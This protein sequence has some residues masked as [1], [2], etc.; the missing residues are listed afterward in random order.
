[1]SDHLAQ[2][3]YPTTP[4]VNKGPLPDIFVAPQS[5]S[6]I[7]AVEEWPTC[8]Q[9]WLD[10]I[11]NDEYGGMPPQPSKVQFELQST[12]V[13]RAWPGQPR[14]WSYKVICHGGEQSISFLVKVL[15]PQS[16]KP[17]PVIINGDACWW[18]SEEIAKMVV[19][20]GF[21]LLL[22]D[23]TELAQDVEE[24]RKIPE[25]CVGGLYDVY[26]GQSFGALSAWAWAYQRCVDLVYELPFLD[27]QSITVSGHSRGGKTCLIAAATDERITLINDNASCAA[28]GAVFRYV[29]DCGEKLSNIVRFTDWFP[30]S[31]SEFK[32]REEDLLYDQHC[33]LAAL[34]PR[35]LLLTYGIDD[36]WSNPEGMVQCV[37]AA[38]EAYRLL[39]MGDKIAFHLRPG[40][41]AHNMQ[42]WSVLIDFIRW[43]TEG[44]EPTSAFN[45]HPYQHLK[46]IYDWAVPALK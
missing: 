14:Y 20:E 41:H 5:Q 42:D 16:D 27:E 29:G 9:A 18:R 37:W 43:Q 25:Q 23:R 26:P 35:P 33:L 1:M 11:I 2:N 4:S 31:L 6:R 3:P 39:G 28:G 17:V 44:R 13:R 32:D 19:A 22:F 34:A 10:L 30:P 36:R 46:P 8:V 21:G 45:Q 7:E 40:T 12:H 38:K 24:D 15:Y